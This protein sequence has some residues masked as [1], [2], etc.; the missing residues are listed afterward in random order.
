MAERKKKLAHVAFGGDWSETR[1]TNEE[2]RDA[3]SV[4]GDAVQK[5][6]DYDV[7]NDPKLGEALSYVEQRLGRGSELSKAFR[8]VLDESIQAVRVDRA[9]AVH[10]RMCEWAGL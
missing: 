8:V 10:R 9:A 3:L 5:C 7:R 4:I 1:L 2:L 6:A